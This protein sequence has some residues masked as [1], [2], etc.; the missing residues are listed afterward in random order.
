MHI[1]M[2]EHMRICIYIIYARVC[3]FVRVC[4]CMCVYLYVCVHIVSLI[5]DGGAASMSL[6]RV[7]RRLL[8]EF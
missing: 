4:I 5:P 1:C 6:R 2:Y 7:E 8:T 3:V